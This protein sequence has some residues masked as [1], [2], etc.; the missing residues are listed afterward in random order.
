M[1]LLS[2]IYHPDPSDASHT[3]QA[4]IDP[5]AE[6]K[7][8]GHPWKM[9]FFNADGSPVGVGGGEIG[10]AGPEGPEGPIGPKGDP[11]D[12]GPQGDIG[13]PGPKGD[14]G[15]AGSDGLPGPKGDTGAQGIQ[16][17]KGDTGAQG[18]QGVKGDTGA[19]GIQGVKGDTGN[20]GAVGATFI[21]SWSSAT[22]Y[23]AR[24]VVTYNGSS[25]V[26]MAAVAAGGTNPKSDTTH[27][28]EIAHG[29]GELARAEYV[30][31]PAVGPAAAN[32]QFNIPGLSIVVPAGSGPFA[33]EAYIVAQVSYSASAVSSNATAYRALILDEANNIVCQAIIKHVPVAS[34]SMLSVLNPKRTVSGP[35]AAD[36]TYRL[37]LLIDSF[38]NV[39]N[40]VFYGDAG[41]AAATT[42]IGPAFIQAVAK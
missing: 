40:T 7:A 29:G 35:L 17:V 19:Q 39:V 25:Y 12:P 18:I 20:T 32:T 8:N 11:G 30:A 23:N 9:A 16:G 10:P 2:K 38:T 33:L 36:K 37:A 6:F 27:W 15:L 41:N 31:G 26:A 5:S 28:L 14:T 3:I 13:P 24:D 42:S 4:V 1:G 34:V 21:G 22:A